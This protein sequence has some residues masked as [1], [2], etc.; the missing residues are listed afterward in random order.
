MKKLYIVYGESGEYDE[1]REYDVIGYFD[2]EE[3]EKHKLAAQQVAD[4]IYIKQQKNILKNF[5]NKYDEYHSGPYHVT[6]DIFELEI[7]EKFKP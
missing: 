2:R 5:K 6:Y 1:H 7:G 3:A 4:Q